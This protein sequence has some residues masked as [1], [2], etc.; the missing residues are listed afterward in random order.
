MDNATLT[1]LIT[2]GGSI[3]VAIITGSTAL[4]TEAIKRGEPSADASW[5]RWLKNLG[6]PIAALLIIIAGVVVFQL[7]HDGAA[8]RLS[9]ELPTISYH[10]K[11]IYPSVGLGFTHPQKWEVEDY[12]FRFS[13]GGEMRLVG[14]R[15][16][17]G[18]IETQGATISIENI[19][20]HHWKDPESEFRHLEDGLD[21]RCKSPRKSRETAAIA[22]GRQAALFK[23]DRMLRNGG[24]ADERIYW[25]QLS[26]CLR[27]KIR[28]WSD[29]EG[30]AKDGFMQEFNQFVSNIRLDDIKIH[31]LI[32]GKQTGCERLINHGH[33]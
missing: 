27:L 12:A 24:I 28:G 6:Y 25:Y 7:D 31:S 10:T 4:I 17:D 20:E 26:R 22:N 32:N 11:R 15:S 21:M 16:A 13:G 30:K 3:A 1:A 29:L 14:T 19:A 18:H 2:V 9:K 33:A 5:R 8:A 23:C